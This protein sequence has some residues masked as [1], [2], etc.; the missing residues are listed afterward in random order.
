MAATARCRGRQ[1]L[2]QRMDAVGHGALP[3][4]R[5]PVPPARLLTPARP[6]HRCP[7]LHPAGGHPAGC[8][9]QFWW[10]CHGSSERGILSSAPH[11][12]GDLHAQFGGRSKVCMPAAARA[13]RAARTVGPERRQAGSHVLRQAIPR[14]TAA[15]SRSRSQT[16]ARRGEH[17]LRR[18]RNPGGADPGRTSSRQRRSDRLCQSVGTPRLLPR[19]GHSRA[20]KPG[21]NVGAGH[22]RRHGRR[23]APGSIRS[24]RLRT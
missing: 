4:A 15:R 14:Q 8:L 13:S 3:R 20:A 1:W 24:R 5:C 23:N 7:A 21:R 6:V 11:P 22:Q 17:A 9:C 16:P 10:P 19:R 12:A 2:H 18:G